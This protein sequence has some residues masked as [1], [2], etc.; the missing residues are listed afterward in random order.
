MGCGCCVTTF[1]DEV[2]GEVF[3]Y[4]KRLKKGNEDKNN[5]IQEIQKDLL[6]RCEIIEKYN[7]PYRYDDV[8]KTV[9][10]YKNYIYRKFKGHV[11]LLED[12]IKSKEKQEK[13]TK[14]EILK[15][16]ENKLTLKDK[17]QSE[18]IK[19]SKNIDNLKENNEKQN[20][21]NMN[22]KKENQNKKSID[23]YKKDEKLENILQSDLQPMLED[24][25]KNYSE[26]DESKDIKEKSINNIKDFIPKD[27]DNSVK[28]G[29]NIIE[30]EEDIKSL[31]S[32]KNS[33]K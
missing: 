17:I 18:Q 2:E 7:Y 25:I 19:D 32:E 4:I 13:Q 30:R 28:K 23:D 29:N 1:R 16:D 6:K 15:T 5:L 20:S 33:E 21:N 11:E 31:K 8:E 3:S 14:Q 12:K 22:D 27:K 26:R 9:K 24:K 10:I